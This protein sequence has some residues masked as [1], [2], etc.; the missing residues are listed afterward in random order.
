MF[1]VDAHEDIA[2]NVLHYDRDV[3]YP[4]ARIRE[5]EMA[6]VAAGCCAPGG[7]PET[8]LVSLREHQR[9]RVGLVF[10]TIFTL[11]GP[12]DQMTADGQAQLAYYHSLA[13]TDPAAR[14]VVS[15]A[16]L[17]ALLE[18]WRSDGDLNSNPVGLVLLLEGADAL[19]TPDELA[20]WHE[21]GLRIAGPAWR[22]TKYAGGTREPGPITAAGRD[23]LRQM[24]VLG[25][26]LDTSHLAEE[27][28]WQA[29]DQFTGPVIASHSNCRALVPGD[30][31]LSDDM[32]R[33]LAERDG[34]IGTVLANTFLLAN[35]QPGDPVTL[36]TVVRHIDH[37][38]Q[39]SG[40]A[41]H[42]AIGSDFDGG[43]GVEST[44][45]EFESVADLARIGDAL[46]RHGY[47]EDDITA[48]LGGNWLRFLS[49]AL[50][51]I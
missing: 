34:V 49:T 15:R 38:C 4:L 1:I 26:T 8:A 24:D 27:S 2:H 21:Q 42:C 25:M 16:S 41:R 11:P 37:V 20:T 19:R 28:F 51:P 44:P 3:R 23:L 48:I 7:V 45:E 6:R 40:T 14:L 31:H 9:G 13:G 46:A 33:A 47:A 12:Q 10:A 22:A 50:P 18:D 30:R 17:G 32:I 5:L 35:W 43:F 36:D 39:L 29:L